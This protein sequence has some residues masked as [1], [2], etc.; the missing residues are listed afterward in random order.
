[1][2][3]RRL[4]FSMSVYVFKIFCGCDD[5]PKMIDTTG[6]DAGQP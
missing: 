3:Y 5:D 1:M 4:T 2:T 6:A